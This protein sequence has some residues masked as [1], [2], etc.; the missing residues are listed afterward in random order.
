MILQLFN[1]KSSLKFST[2]ILYVAVE[3]HNIKQETNQ[4]IA[5]KIRYCEE[6]S[7]SYEIIDDWQSHPFVPDEDTMKYL[8]KIKRGTLS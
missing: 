2:I 5:W 8:D 7:A 1:S 4:D 3:G 6:L